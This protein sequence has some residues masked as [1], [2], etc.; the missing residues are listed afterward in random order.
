[1]NGNIDNEIF[2]SLIL[3]DGIKPIIVLT[4]WML[5]ASIIHSQPSIEWQ[6]CLGG[7]DNDLGQFIQQTPDSGYIALG[8]TDSTDGD[9]TGN[10]GEDIWIVKLDE[11]GSIQWQKCLIDEQWEAAEKLFQTTDGGFVITGVKWNGSDDDLVVIKL[12]INGDTE[13]IKYFGGPGNNGGTSILQTSDNGY[14][15]GG[16]SD[17]LGGDVTENFGYQDFWILKLNHAGVL[18]WEKS[19]G[20]SNVE[21]PLSMDYASDNGFILIGLTAS[22]DG[23]ITEPLGLYDIWVVR[24]DSSG[25]L[26]WQKTLGGRGND[27]SEAIRLTPDGNY[28]LAASTTSN[29]ELVPGNHGQNDLLAYKLDDEGNIIW[30]KIYGGSGI[31]GGLSLDLTSD[32]G[33]IIAGYTTSPDDG[34]VSGHHTLH[35]YWVVKLDANGDLSWQKC[36]GGSGIDVAQSIQQTNDG[37][38]IVAGYSNSE[39]LQNYHGSHDFFIVKL[40]VALGAYSET[41]HPDITIYP[42]PANNVLHFQDNGDQRWDRIEII[43]LVGVTQGV[44]KN[45]ET[46]EINL[47]HLPDGYYLLKFKNENFTSIR[48]FYKN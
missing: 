18:Q 22:V 7:S 16:A 40:S 14:I 13:W 35:D 12:D 36:L 23:H 44:F 38:F 28:V 29:D 4:L 48:T 8:T 45:I 26:L 33:F 6:T 31:D 21:F 27:V 9:V 47:S 43:N 19:F 5:S 41:H 2:F 39:E 42:N 10:H 3:V 30:Q 11:T 37:G 32:N 17:S 34:D 1:M 46:G 25:N 20:G 24:I 15:I